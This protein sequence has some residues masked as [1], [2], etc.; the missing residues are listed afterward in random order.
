MRAA[1][2]DLITLGLAGRAA[3]PAFTCYGADTALAVVNAA[4]GLGLPVILLVAPSSAGA[5]T[6]PRLIRTLRAIADD[7]AVPVCVQLD[8][9]KD[10]ALLRTAIAAGADA[11][12]ADGSHL[13]ADENA[14]FVRQVREFAAP[15][16]VIVEAEL[17]SIPGAEDHASAQTADDAGKTDPG[18]VR[19]FLAESGAQLLACGVGNVH[20]R[21]RGAPAIDWPLL[22]R[23]REEAGSVPLVLHGASGL[24]AADLRACGAAGVGKVNVN[25]ELRTAMLAAAEDRIGPARAAGEDMLTFTRTVLA[26]ATGVARDVLRTLS[27]R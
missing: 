4:E 21:Y 23:L 12:L 10:A 17:G 18:L 14:A 15:R 7:S 1:L 13:P 5:D 6:G 16:G 27:G 11:V 20:G 22:A 24:P 2:D 9:A 8:H 25:T 26:A 3:V 19:D